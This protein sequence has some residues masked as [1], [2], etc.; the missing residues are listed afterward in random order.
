M[1]SM[2]PID[3]GTIA[4]A[5]EKQRVPALASGVPPPT[6]LPG[7]ALPAQGFCSPQCSL[8]IDQHEGGQDLCGHWSR[9]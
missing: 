2:R 1:R 8:A 6:S 3:D 9:C 4:N 7:F 5:M